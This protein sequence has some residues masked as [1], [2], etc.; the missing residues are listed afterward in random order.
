MSNILEI[1]FEVVMVYYT[2]LQ[3]KITQERT[4]KG[5]KPISFLGQ[6]AIKVGKHSLERIAEN[7]PY[8]H[9]QER[10]QVTR[11]WMPH[12]GNKLT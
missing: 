3:P 4:T 5:Q 9:W 10:I 1:L 8:G 6:E 7:N 11:T 12:K 2:N